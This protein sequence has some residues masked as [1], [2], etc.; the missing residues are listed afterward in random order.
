MISKLNGC[1]AG[2]Y[3][4]RQNS[5]GKMM[6][7]QKNAADWINAQFNSMLCSVFFFASTPKSDFGWIDILT[8]RR[9][10]SHV[11]YSSFKC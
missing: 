8:D 5:I 4:Q 10:Q 1:L 9:H 6:C 2:E 3:L 11:I 7:N